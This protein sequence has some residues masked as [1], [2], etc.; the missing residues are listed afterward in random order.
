MCGCVLQL[1][2]AGGCQ[3]WGARVGHV[4]AH[5][6]EAPPGVPSHNSECLGSGPW[7]PEFCWIDSWL[8][9]FCWDPSPLPSPLLPHSPPPF[10]PASA[11]DGWP[12]GGLCRAVSLPPPVSKPHSCLGTPCPC[13]PHLTS[14]EV[15]PGQIT[16]SYCLPSGLSDYGSHPFA[17]P[18]FL[19]GSFLG[20]SHTMQ[21]ITQERCGF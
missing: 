6:S 16:T 3:G 2:Q 7:V 10:A 21:Q 4:C 19:S 14:S 11:C 20:F 17:V 13:L 18:A 9:L 12:L 1:G 15:S 8:C 5:S